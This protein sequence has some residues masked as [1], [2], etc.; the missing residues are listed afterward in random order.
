MIESVYSEIGL[1]IRNRVAEHLGPLAPFPAGLL[2][3]QLKPRIGASPDDLRPIDHIATVGCP[4][5]VISGAEDS[6]TPA[7]ETE[8][9]FAAAAE[10]KQLWLV[11][12]VG[13]VDLR[14]TATVDYDQRVLAFWD[15]HLAANF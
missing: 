5:F 15:T 13:H 3:V 8:L 6:H 4:I 2:L 12:Q 11:P 1:A 14:K 7:S 10:P 9:L